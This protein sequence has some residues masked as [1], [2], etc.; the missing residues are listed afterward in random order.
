MKLKLMDMEAFAQ[1]LTPVTS[2]ESKTRT[3]EWN[4]EGLF[5]ELI[6]GIEGSPQRLKT[7]SYID[8][9]TYV[10]HPSIYNIL[11]R[12]NQKI[13]SLFSTSEYF[14][15]N[16][17]GELVQDDNG[18]T[19]IPEFMKNFKKI[20]F[21]GG[22]ESRDSLIELINK[23]YKN[24]TIFLRKIP[25][26]PPEFRPE[27]EDERGATITDEINDIYVS[28]IKKAT[29]LKSIGSGP[30][31][32]NLV[33]G[34]QLAINAHEAFI[35]KKI[36]KKSGLIRNEMLGKRVDFSGRGVIV[37]GPDLD[38]NQV[39]LPLRLAVPLFE[40]FLLNYFLYSRKNPNIKEFKEE[41]E[42][43]L[44][45]ALNVESLKRLFR[46]V[47]KGADIP[48]LLYDMI[49]E[50]TSIVMRDRVVIS[51]R[52]PVL[53]DGSYRAFTPI[54]IPGNII[55]MCTLQV[56][57]FNA[58]FDGDQMGFFHPL[59]DQAQQEAKEKMMKVVG[60]ENDESVMFEL[61]KEMCLGLFT[62]TKN[63][64]R[65]QS[66]IGIT[67]AD[68]EKA[69]DPYIQVK[70]R[71]KNT[72]MG[73]AIFNSAFPPSMPFIDQQVTKKFVNGLINEV[74][75]KYGQDVSIKVFSK[76]EKIG[77]KFATLAG[78]SITLDMLDVP[79][80][81]LELK[82]K[83]KGSSPEEVT[84]LENQ[85]I[86]IMKDN[87]KGSGLYDLMESGA[88]KGWSQPK[89]IL[90]A[91]GMITDTKGKLLDPIEGSFSDGLKATEY[92]QAAAG[93]RKGMADRALNT[94]DTGYFTRQLVYM[95]SP[96][97]AGR[98][99]KD[100]DCGTKRT[101]SLQLNGDLLGRLDGRFYIKGGKLLEY[102]KNDF[103]A[104]DMINLR[105]PIYCINKKVCMTCYGKL[106][107][108]HKSPYI[109]IIAGS[110][111]GERGTQ[112]IMR[113]GDGLVHYNGNLIPFVD[114]FNM[115]K[116]YEE[117]N[118]IETVNFDGYVNGKDKPVKASV[119]QRHEPHD[120]MLFIKTKSGHSLICQANHPLWIKKNPIHS[121][122]NNKYCRL[123]GENT[124][125]ETM[126]TRKPFT[127]DDELEEII[128]R[129]VKKYDAIW[130][131]NSDAMY[132]TNSITP[133]IS[134]YVAGIYCAEGC[135]IYNDR[136]R[137]ANHISQN[138][139]GPIKERIYR[140]CLKETFNSVTKTP[141][142]ITFWDNGKRRVNQIILGDYAWEKRLR[143]DFINYDANWLREFISGLADGDGSVFNFRDTSTC[144]RIYTT[145][146]YLVQQ[147]DAI[148]QKLG[149]KFN[150]GKGTYSKKYNRTRLSFQ[151]DIRF[152]ENPNLSSEKFK[153]VKF[154]PISI[155]KEK[156]IKGFDPIILIKEI[157]PNAWRYPVYDIKTETKEYM[158]GF[159]QNHNTFHTGG[160]ATIAIADVLSDILENDPLL[161][162]NKNQLKAYFE[163]TDTIL[164]TKRPMKITIDLGGYRTNDN[165]QYPDNAKSEFPGVWLN[166]VVA[167]VEFSDLVFDLALDYAVV[168]KGDYKKGSK[169]LVVEYK[170]NEPVLD[171]PTTAV[172]IK[173]QV[174]YIKRLLGGKMVYKDPSHLLMKIFKVYGPVSDLDLV[175]M[176]VLASQVLRDKSN[177]AI[178]ARLG[179]TW[180]PTMANVKENVFS[181]SFL[182][183][184]AFE[185]IS[186]A[187]QVGLI[188]KAEFDQPTIFE[189]LITGEDL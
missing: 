8:L 164:Y 189:K 113:C 120:R 83:I 89:Q 146:Y 62:M 70:Y 47:K 130:I 139:E 31:Y 86:K 102:S 48:K 49:F 23:S 172:E 65:L 22:T 19:G 56:G 16:S 111:I 107:Q 2:V 106:V 163:Q 91:K 81:I 136:K 28:I 32:D 95:L 185:N 14:K 33:Y 7:Y 160:A 76:L 140:E 78:S 71:G 98:E 181:T 148:C 54:L 173:E 55:Q 132:N 151:C 43:Y 138:T 188:E 129:D 26:I 10:I 17:K 121:K 6:F 13:V 145:S 35:Q 118:G 30:V 174:N 165:I 142:G 12:L 77:F 150:I 110:K 184:A 127:T 53:H 34:M 63:V 92:F 178:P 137:K 42:A 93:A 15:I 177:P 144:V 156:I 100:R 108:R 25:V 104:G 114:L 126:S 85:M 79:D 180:N 9:E 18:F 123:I 154:I 68:M 124:Y 4:P 122:Y 115:G 158:M 103:K 131:D 73:K 133:E 119:I 183:G 74:I 167:Q 84:K 61:S 75:K 46:S 187:I 3:G 116:N 147:L 39:G 69:T 40:P 80:S 41:A 29:Q 125:T 117:N 175:H 67:E 97:E 96:V 52:D 166:H 161:N 5:S 88:G 128:A 169:R 90:I 58:D 143:Y 44:E 27:Y 50:A 38:I 153:S 168:L 159:V 186:K 152:L 1:G 51:K 72:T 66:P 36:S 134:G 141:Q 87:L 135:K 60:S 64:K 176:E 109:G 45:G 94:A 155:R 162:M 21:Q 99:A 20:K 105:T 82:K 179:K 112:L 157:E 171:V 101:I 170:A 149:Y 57:P 11:K 182:Q 37:T 59:S 24:Q